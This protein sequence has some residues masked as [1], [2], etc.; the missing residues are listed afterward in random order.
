MKPPPLSKDAFYELMIIATKGVEFSFGN[1]MLKQVDGVAMGST[2]G[3]VL[4]NIFVGYHETIFF[5][6]SCCQDLPEWYKRY[7]D[8]SF[9]LFITE[10]RARSFL[11]SFNNIYPSLKFT[12]E[13]ENQ[14]K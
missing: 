8:D 9:S 14:R 13:F 5:N 4:A 11:N 1:T 6:E 12:C 3:P 10:E 7:A 2:L